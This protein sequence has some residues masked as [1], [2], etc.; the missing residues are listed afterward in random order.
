MRGRWVSPNARHSREAAEF[1]GLLGALL[2]MVAVHSTE[3]ALFVRRGTTHLPARTRASLLVNH[4]LSD[5]RLRSLERAVGGPDWRVT[6]RFEVDRGTVD[7]MMCDVL[8]ATEAAGRFA[9]DGPTLDWARFP[10]LA[11]VEQPPPRYV[12]HI[13]RL[14]AVMCETD[15][16]LVEIISTAA[17]GAGGAAGTGARLARA[18]RTRDAMTTWGLPAE[19]VERLH[20]EN[21]ALAFHTLVAN[22]RCGSV[23]KASR[24]VAVAAATLVARRIDGVDPAETPAEGAS[25]IE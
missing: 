18:G 9:A 7:M 11:G 19:T 6:D 12:R 25:T 4:M 3:S 14:D 20:D 24:E 10:R 15:P 23:L 16:S 2:A 1:V 5:E 22:L 13:A 17:D 21:R 8:V